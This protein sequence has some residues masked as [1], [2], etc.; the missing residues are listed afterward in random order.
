[1]GRTIRV[2]HVAKYRKPKTKEEE[3]EEGSESDTDTW[4]HDKYDG[5]K[6]RTRD[7]V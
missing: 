3:E 4:D 6:K 7:E 5:V 2:D 1:V